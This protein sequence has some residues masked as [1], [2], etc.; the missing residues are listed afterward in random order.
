M[1][2]RRGAV[3]IDADSDAGRQIDRRDHRRDELPNGFFDGE[4]GSGRAGIGQCEP[5]R[6]NDGQGSFEPPTRPRYHL[7]CIGEISGRTT[8]DI[9]APIFCHGF[10]IVPGSRIDTG[11]RRTNV[12]NQETVLGFR[13][14]PTI[15]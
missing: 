11:C 1:V 6:D 2:E 9:A 14:S 4:R 7:R 8:E 10:L 15:L 3:M 12:G 5:C 13:N